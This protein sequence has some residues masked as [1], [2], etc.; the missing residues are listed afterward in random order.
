MVTME[1]IRLNSFV[2]KAAPFFIF[3]FLFTIPATSNNE[4]THQSEMSRFG[5]HLQSNELVGVYAVLKD[6][7]TGLDTE[8]EYALATAIF[9]YSRTYGIDPFFILAMIKTESAFNNWA[10]SRKGALGMMQILPATGE[11]IAMELGLKWLGEETL[12]DPS[13]NVRIGI[14]YLSGLKGRFSNDMKIA[15]AAYNRGPT[16]LSMRLRMGRGLKFRYV[17]AVYSN[18]ED[19]RENVVF[20]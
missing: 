13:A 1:K 6:F 3:I 9:D 10:R 12:F 14:H 2:L 19:L 7:N 4:I 16:D 17:D 8:E 20:N 5:S 11:A 18:Y 15:T